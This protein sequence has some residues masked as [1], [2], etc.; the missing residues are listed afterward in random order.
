ML[1]CGNF[2][3][4]VILVDGMPHLFSPVMVTCWL[5]G[6]GRV[7]KLLLLCSLICWL[8]L[9][10][11]ILLWRPPKLTLFTFTPLAAFNLVIEPTPPCKRPVDLESPNLAALLVYPECG[12]GPG[13][14]LGVFSWCPCPANC[15]DK[16]SGKWLELVWPLEVLM[17]VT[18]D[19]EGAFSCCC[20]IWFCSRRDDNVLAEV[21]SFT[22]VTFPEDVWAVAVLFDKRFCWLQL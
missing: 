1:V 2:T 3:P 7:I 4:E 14:P 16:I 6:G 10:R 21:L 12:G 5:S 17:T 15:E 9:R 11:V 22:I 18:W 19:L 20:C 8:E 13:I